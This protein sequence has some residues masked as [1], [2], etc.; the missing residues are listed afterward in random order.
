MVP[1]H[2]EQTEMQVRWRG[3]CARELSAKMQAS[4][5]IGDDEHEPQATKTKGVRFEETRV[6]WRR[7]EG[8]E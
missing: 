3:D 4:G 5:M 7:C 6:R 1:A 8:K 2:G